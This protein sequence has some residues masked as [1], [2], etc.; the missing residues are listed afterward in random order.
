MNNLSCAVPGFHPVFTG[1]HCE[2]HCGT[3]KMRNISYGGI[4]KT[5]VPAGDTDQYRLQKSP[6]NQMNLRNFVCLVLWEIQR[7]IHEW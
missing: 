2:A 5:T 1:Q 7:K 6:L 3:D 4:S